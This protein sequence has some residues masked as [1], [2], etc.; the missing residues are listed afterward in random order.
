MPATDGVGGQG[1][2]WQAEHVRL[3]V[4]SVEPPEMSPRELWKRVVGQE[5]EQVSEKPSQGF[6]RIEGA[7]EGDKLC[8]TAQPGRMDWL[9]SAQTEAGAAPGGFS[10]I[11]PATSV[12]PAFSETMRNWLLEARGLRPSRIA[13]GAVLLQEVDGRE[14][15]YER[16]RA[17]LPFDFRSP[18]ASDFSFRINRPRTTTLDIPG[19]QINRLCTWSVVVLQGIAL[20]LNLESGTPNG[21]ITEKRHACRLELDVNTA[22]DYEG[23]L[24][25]D[26]LPGILTEL[27]DLCLEIAAEGDK[28]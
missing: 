9:R 22:P 26:K 13:L 3:T 14:E 21:R 18:G 1:E 11:G 27:S 28:E 20:M 25:Q 24:P 12:L 19:L 8:L 10:T 6:T 7:C 23:E 16:V 5:P 17:Y 2:A 4:F 15:G